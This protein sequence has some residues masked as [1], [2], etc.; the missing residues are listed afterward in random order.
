MDKRAFAVPSVRDI[1]LEEK[2]TDRLNNLTKPLGSLGRLEEIVL[3]YCLCK[4]T[5]EATLSRMKIFTF[6][7]DHG[8]TEEKVTPYPSEVT[9]QI[10]LN[11]AQEG[12]PSA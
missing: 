12:L 11:M 10:V 7:G 9:Y 2:I 4:K 5:V 1:E 3:R 6:A 8:I